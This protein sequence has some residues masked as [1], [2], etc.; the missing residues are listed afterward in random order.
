MKF[1]KVFSVLACAALMA[2]TFACTDKVEPTPSPVAGNEEVYFPY[3]TNPQLAIPVDA[4]QI[5]V[6][7]NRV[8][9]SEES[10][11]A[12]TSAVSYVGGTE[13]APEV[14]PVTDIFTI[15]S[16]VTFPK[17]VKELTLEIGVDF[18]KVV[19]D[20]EYNITLTLDGA[21][22]GAYGLG[23]RTF[24]AVYLPWT[25]WELFN[26]AEPGV[27]QQGA[28]WDNEYNTPVYVR[29]SLTNE[30]LTQ[31]LVLSPF[32]NF[33]YEQII[34]VDSSKKTEVDGVECYEAWM[35]NAIDTP[36]V[37]PNSGTTYSYTTTYTF[38]KYF[39]QGGG[40]FT[41][42]EIANVMAAQ[43]WMPSYFN[44]EKGRFFL[45]MTLYISGGFS[46]DQSLETLQLP[47]EYNDYYFTFNH[48]GNMVSTTGTEYALVQVVPSTDI[49]HFSYAVL[50]GSVSG[51]DLEKAQDELAVDPDVELIYD[52]SYTISYPFKEEGAYTFIAVG[53]DKDNKMVCRG[54]KV[55]TLETVQAASE[56][57]SLGMCDYTDGA[58]VGLLLNSNGIETWEVEVQE[59]K[60][61]PGLYRLVNPYATWPLLSKMGWELLEGKYYIELD[62]TDP[63]AVMMPICPLGVYVDDAINAQ[64]EKMGAAS[65][66]SDAWYTVAVGDAT[67]EQ[68]KAAGLCGT[69]ADD[70]ITF[71]TAGL[72][73]LAGNQKN[74]FYANTDPDRAEGSA[75]D[76]GTGC[77]CVDFSNMKKSSSKKIQRKSA[78]PSTYELK[79]LVDSKAGTFSKKARKGAS[80]TKEEVRESRTFRT[81]L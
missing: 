14:I 55:Y 80:F 38:L 81:N 22:T 45:Y 35:D 78:L 39:Y 1:N 47:G 28:L 6:T 75:I 36:V 73:M 69:L 71:P 34:N 7:V 27:Y 8:D 59:H 15:P 68:V 64:G 30:N 61:T 49:D 29:K 37:D 57:A 16:S 53:F 62:A 66:L 48:Q 43:G 76:S 32:S 46:Q 11:V 44:P 42:A 54:S 19:I 31:Y 5:S 58:F 13:E 10:T 4:T 26:E 2:G 33:E 70:M 17:D 77:F 72:L 3:D 18:E 20:R 74:L 41:D 21:H 56:W 12:L 51:A 23:E 25:D 40:K 79:K 67:F 60:E 63:D 52:A 24:T 50:Q 65:L 9:A